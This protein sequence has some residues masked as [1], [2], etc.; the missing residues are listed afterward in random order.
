LGLSTGPGGRHRGYNKRRQRSRLTAGCHWIGQLWR[1]DR[2]CAQPDGR[3]PSVPLG[4]CRGN[5]QVR[6]QADVSRGLDARILR[7]RADDSSPFLGRGWSQFQDWWREPWPR[8]RAVGAGLQVNLGGFGSIFGGY[9]LQ[10]NG[11]QDYHTGSVGWQI[12]W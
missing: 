12:V 6:L 9:D 8:L 2:I 11:R 10:A 7:Q 3:R 1:P 4:C 5:F